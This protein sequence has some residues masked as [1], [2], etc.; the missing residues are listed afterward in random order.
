MSWIWDELCAV[1][2]DGVGVYLPTYL[3]FDINFKT[4]VGDRLEIAPGLTLLHTP[5]HTPGLCILQVC[6]SNTIFVLDIQSDFCIGY[7]I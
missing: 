2:A 6:I 7:P 1:I 5:G 4:F 3:Q